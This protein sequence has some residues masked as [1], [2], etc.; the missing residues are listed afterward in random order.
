MPNRLL[1][2][3]GLAL[4][5]HNKPKRPR[6]IHEFQDFS[7]SEDSIMKP[8][9]LSSG[10]TVNHNSW[11]K[12]TYI[13]VI[14]GPVIPTRHESP[15]L[16]QLPLSWKSVHTSLGSDRGAITQRTTMKAMNPKICSIKMTPSRPGNFRTRNVFQIIAK[17]AIPMLNSVPCHP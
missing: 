17:M 10:T 14:T 5:C 12:A 2:T 1:C 7:C 4:I 9:L 8:L 6:K 16:P 11:W 3:A 15:M 13:K